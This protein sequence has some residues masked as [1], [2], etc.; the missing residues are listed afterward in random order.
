MVHNGN[1]PVT[2]VFIILE[3]FRKKAVQEIFEK[4][5]AKEKS[6]FFN[7][8]GFQ[9]KAGQQFLRRLSSELRARLKT[10]FSMRRGDQGFEILVNLDASYMLKQILLFKDLLDLEKIDFKI[11]GHGF[12]YPTQKMTT[13]KKHQYVITKI[14]D[15]ADNSIELHEIGRKLT[16][17]L[18]I[19]SLARK[20]LGI[21]RY[22]LREEYSK[23]KQILVMNLVKQGWKLSFIDAQKNITMSKQNE[24]QSFIFLDTMSILTKDEWDAFKLKLVANEKS[25]D[26]ALEEK[27]DKDE[28]DELEP[29]IV[30]KRKE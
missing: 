3:L 22:H 4:M 29:L 17:Y 23:K 27:Q 25:N 19:S 6:S 14:I 10:N 9:T 24:W 16:G 2:D 8:F 30:K 13:E 1:A 5:D 20:Q 26:I 18:G 12:N 28:E 21:S 15:N 11:Q 7:G